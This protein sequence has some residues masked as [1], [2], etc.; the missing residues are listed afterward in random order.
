MEVPE[1]CLSVREGALREAFAPLQGPATEKG[2]AGGAESWVRMFPLPRAASERDSAEPTA[3][4][5]P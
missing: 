5:L 4:R 3:A 1:P 2:S